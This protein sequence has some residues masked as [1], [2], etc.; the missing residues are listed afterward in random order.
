MSLL[1]PFWYQIRYDC[2]LISSKKVCSLNMKHFVVLGKDKQVIA[3]SF[4]L[5]FYTASRMFGIGAVPR[6]NHVLTFP[7][8]R[9][10]ILHQSE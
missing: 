6:P 10:H 5:H 3:I 7:P 2:I 8:H 4:C 9:M 1:Q